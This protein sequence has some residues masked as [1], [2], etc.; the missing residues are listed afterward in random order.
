MDFTLNA[1][2]RDTN[3]KPKELIKSGWVPGCVYGKGME[4]INIQINK[5]TLHEC[6]KKHAKKVNLNVENVGNFLVGLE[7]IQKG[8]LGDYVNHISFH[9]LN[10][11]EKATLHCEIEITGTAKGMKEGGLM[12]LVQSELVIKGFPDQLVDKITIDVTEMH[13]GDFIHVKDIAKKY[14]FE[15]KQ[16]DMEKILVRCQHPN[17]VYVEEVKPEKI[18]TAETAPIAAPAANNVVQLP[19]ASAKTTDKVAKKKAA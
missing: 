6:L 19:A 17:V 13:L 11:K 5:A 7:E 9:A 3:F 2:K 14:K 10:K 4:T 16:E 18:E 15:F 8:S 12:H 1:K